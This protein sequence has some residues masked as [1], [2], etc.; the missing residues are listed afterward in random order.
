MVIDETLSRAS[1]LPPAGFRS[2][3]LSEKVGFLSKCKNGKKLRFVQPA[4]LKRYFVAATIDESERELYT[5]CVPIKTAHKTV[6]NLWLNPSV[7]QRNLLLLPVLPNRLSAAAVVNMALAAR[8]S[9]CSWLSFTGGSMAA[10]Q[11]MAQRPA[12]MR[13]RR[14]QLLRQPQKLQPRWP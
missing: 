6:P 4:S 13:H 8:L 7:H 9:R 1:S 5:F 12:P 10:R 11:A 2:Y 14:P 3:L